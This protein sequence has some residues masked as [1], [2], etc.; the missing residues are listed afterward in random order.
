MLKPLAALLRSDLKN[1]SRDRFFLLINWL[2]FGVALL[3]RYLVPLAGELV[4]PW[5]NL[6]AYYPLVAAFMAIMTP[7]M[8]GALMG[9]MLLDDRDED[10][11]TYVSVTPLTKSGYLVYRLTIAIVVSIPGM[12]G[13]LL[14]TGLEPV[15]FLRLLPVA[16]MAALEAP[17]AALFIA[18]LA[19][20]KV[21]GLAVNK[22]TGFLFLAP[23]IAYLVPG[24]WHY[25][26]GVL[27]TFWIAK[28]YWA[29]QQQTGGYLA[30]VVIGF[31]I[32]GFCILLLHAFYRHRRG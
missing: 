21:E 31:I 32:H 16:L 30:Y 24:N 14:L 3:M 6:R 4:K 13:V 1:I 9:F 5:L 17:L 28:A 7:N 15:P 10:I 18:A 19:N 11:L 25:L 26:G 29:A 20:N 12:Y 2:P 23:F 22:L 27:P 8:L